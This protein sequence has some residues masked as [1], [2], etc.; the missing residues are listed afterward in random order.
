[1]LISKSDQEQLSFHPCAWIPAQIQAP[2]FGC[3]TGMLCTFTCQVLA[4]KAWLVSGILW[5]YLE[6]G[7]GFPKGSVFVELGVGCL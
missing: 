4:H 5:E 3:L 1:M 6:S 7:N 2:P